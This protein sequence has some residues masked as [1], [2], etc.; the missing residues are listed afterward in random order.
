VKKLANTNHG[1][2]S[3]AVECR[4]EELRDRVLKKVKNSEIDPVYANCYVYHPYPGTEFQQY[5]IEH[6]LMVE[7]LSD[8]IG[9]SFYDRYWKSNK[10]LN[11]IINLQRVF[12]LA[13]KVPALKNPL[14]YLAKN[15][16]HITVD[17]VFG[18]YY[19]WHLIYYNH[20]APSRV[21]QLIKVWGA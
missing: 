11:R 3:I 2:L 16:W 12:G 18:V 6:K 21:Y 17:L 10:E 15:N 8:G 7:S 14:V 19:T 1:L 13:V 9:L 20:L 4:D 5:A